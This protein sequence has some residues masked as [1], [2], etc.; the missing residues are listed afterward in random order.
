MKAYSPT[1]QTLHGILRGEYAAFRLVTAL[2]PVGGDGD[3]VFPP[4]YSTDRRSDK[5]AK[6]HRII[7]GL[8]CLTVL[9]DSVQS[10]ANRAEAALQD[11]YDAG[12]LD[13]PM[14]EVTFPAEFSD[15]GRVTVLQAPHRLAD[16]I[17]RDSSLEGRPWRESEPGKAFVQATLADARG[18]LR[19]APTALILGMWDS[20]GERGG[21]GN[22][23]ARA[24]VSEIIGVGVKVGEKTSSRL[25]PLQIEKKGAKLYEHAIEGWTLNPAEAVKDK[26]G[27][28]KVLTA[29]DGSGDGSPSAI[30]HGNIAPSIDTEAG[31]VSISYA[32]Q[33]SVLSLTRLRMLRFGGSPSDESTLTARTY[34]AVLGLVSIV[35]TRSQGCWLRS[36]CELVPIP[37]RTHGLELVAANGSVEELGNLSVDDALNLVTEAAEALRKHQMIPDK[38]AK[39]QLTPS[40]KLLE[41]LRRSRGMNPQPA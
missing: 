3:K 15:V 29:A 20:T 8:E 12:K 2:R 39:L 28:P 18:I 7:N 41:L 16:A 37:E 35:A 36:R 10:Q 24:L 1:C 4:T 13:I 22:K 14:V 23:F 33:T 19:S 26:D 25:D 34:L 32:L 9:L 17:L 27:K 21:S 30:N 40:P 6:E 5:Y 31:G 38:G 11:L